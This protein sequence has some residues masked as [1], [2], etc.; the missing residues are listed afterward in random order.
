MQG[1]TDV[2]FKQVLMLLVEEG[3]VDLEDLYVDGSKWEANANRHQVVWRK[4]T[5]RHQGKVEQRIEALL[6]EIK[7]LQVA[8]DEQYGRRDLPEVGEGKEISVVLN[9]ARVSEQLIKLQ[10]LI[11][12]KSEEK[13]QQKALKKIERRLREER[14]KLEKY[15][16]QE[17]LLNGRNSYSKTDVDATALRMKD[18]RLLPGYNVQHTTSGGQYIVNWTMEQSASDSPTLPS[19]LDKLVERQQGLPV[20]EQQ[21]LGADAGYGSEENYADLGNRALNA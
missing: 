5:L 1:M 14:Q 20:P 2:V 15:E 4:N 11:E 21:N 17:R 8:E 18:D 12:Q 9:S 13:A 3:Y 7:K 6:E 19:H 10:A 16:E